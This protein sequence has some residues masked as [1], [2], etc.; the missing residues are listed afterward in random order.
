M[1]DVKV[2]VLSRCE[3]TKILLVAAALFVEQSFFF[4]LNICIHTQVTLNF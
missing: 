1:A 4:L 2:Q 3:V